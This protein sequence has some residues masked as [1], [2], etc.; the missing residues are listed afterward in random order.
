MVKD[1]T[2]YSRTRPMTE[3]LGKRSWRL[4]KSTTIITSSFKAN[5]RAYLKIHYKSCFFK[6]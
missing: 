2:H 3:V 4:Q 1:N 6:F 5:I